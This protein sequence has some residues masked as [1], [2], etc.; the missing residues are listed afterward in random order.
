MQI[1]LFETLTPA[2]VAKLKKRAHE[3]ELLVWLLPVYYPPDRF[4]KPTLQVEGKEPIPQD[5]WNKTVK[6]AEEA[7]AIRKKLKE[8]YQFPS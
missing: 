5:V 6:H 4:C 1:Q 8:T 2:E 3:L 7:S